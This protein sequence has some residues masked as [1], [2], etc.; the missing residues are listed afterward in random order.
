[1]NQ[2]K[3]KELETQIKL[4]KNHLNSLKDEQAGLSRQ[5]NDILKCI[6]KNET[7][8]ASF[9][10]NTIENDSIIITEH[11]ILRY[12]ERVKG[13]DISEIKKEIVDNKLFRKIKALGSGYYPQ[14]SQENNIQFRVR[15]KEN[16]VVT[17]LTKE[18]VDK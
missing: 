16:A 18:H 8:I 6:R 1:M 11:A 5:I 9:K 12:L 7:A 10:S 15:V 14:I 3:I 4:S 13:L 17:I 2:N